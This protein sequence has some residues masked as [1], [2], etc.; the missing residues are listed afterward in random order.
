MSDY[1]HALA[2]AVAAA[3]EAGRTLRAGFHNPG[4]PA[5]VDEQAEQ[6]IRARLLAACDWR[7]LGEE[8]GSGGNASS[9]HC[10]VVDPNDGTASF[11]KGR[12]GSAVSIAALRDGAPVLGVV[13]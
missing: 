6:Q 12:R 1:Q 13:Y 5:N 7:Y 9:D 2:A 3:Q 11:L 10:W 8:T 4:G